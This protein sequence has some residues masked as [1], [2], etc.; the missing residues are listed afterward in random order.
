MM[1]LED[2]PGQGPFRQVMS[3]WVVLTA[4]AFA[5]LVVSMI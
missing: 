1:A 3:A 5:A 2:R 4:V